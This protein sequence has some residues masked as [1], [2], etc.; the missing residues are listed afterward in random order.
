MESSRLRRNCF[1]PPRGPSQISTIAHVSDRAWKELTKEGVAGRALAQRL[2]PRR[3]RGEISAGGGDSGDKGPRA[4][5]E[6][7]CEPRRL[8]ASGEP[9]RAPS[10]LAPYAPV[11]APARTWLRTRAPGAAPP[12]RST[13]RR[14]SPS[15]R[16]RAAGAA[17]GAGRAGAPC[18]GPW[19]PCAPPACPPRSGAGGEAGWAGRFAEAA[20][21]PCPALP[22]PAQPV[23]P[24][25][26]PASRLPLCP[27]RAAP[28]RRTSGTG[29][30][31]GP[32][33]LQGHPGAGSSARPRG[34]RPAGGLRRRAPRPLRAGQNPPRGHPPLGRTLSPRGPTGRGET[35]PPAALPPHCSH[36]TRAGG[37]L[38]PEAGG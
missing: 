15:R 27:G 23:P 9:R 26:L 12:A 5:A 30:R 35:P 28:G 1:Y 37:I 29:R 4:S 31:D 36:G 10:P 18:P 14:G 33:R 32:G 21:L 13:G 20:V 7:H 11:R 17:G 6:P 2:R 38:T 3:P 34:L 24:R 25:L 8:R 22:R 16:R 19:A